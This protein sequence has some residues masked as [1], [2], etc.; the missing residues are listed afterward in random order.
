[1]NYCSSDSTSNNSD[2][3]TEN[4]FIHDSAPYFIQP[5]TVAEQHEEDYALGLEPTIEIKD[6]PY[7]YYP[8]ME[9]LIHELDKRSRVDSLSSQDVVSG[10][11]YVDTSFDDLAMAVEA[12]SPDIIDGKPFGFESVF[13]PSPCKF[14]LRWTDEMVRPLAPLQSPFL[15]LIHVG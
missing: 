15:Y 2:R 7:V 13:P 11:S 5:R 10:F 6:E 4:D 14:R 3:N 8:A 12:N 1:M 9:S